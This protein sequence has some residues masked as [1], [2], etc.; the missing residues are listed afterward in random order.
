LATTTYLKQTSGALTEVRTVETSAGAGDASKIPN[1]TSAGILD[2]TVINA[3]ATTAANKIAKMNGSGILDDTIINASATSSAGK[4]V[5]MNGSGII[6]PTILNGTT[7]S[8]GAGDSAKFV[9][10]DST[11]RLDSTFLPVGVGAETVTATATEAISSGDVVNLY[12]SSGLKVRKADASN[13]REAH[14]FVL[15]AISNTA[16]GSVYV[17]GTD[18]G[19]S[20]RT[21]GAT[22]FLSA[23]TP[24]AVTETAPSTAGQI[25][26]VVGY[27]TGATQFT[28]ER[29]LPI[30]LA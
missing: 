22:Q 19:V 9:Q 17:E 30:T 5:K 25:V 7:T 4:V 20:S 3:S 8:A 24:G 29:S 27:A 12:N 16:T 23:T 6:A 26:Q 21:P 28:F 11:G 18:T 14:G 13:G 2:D 15:A 1:L 10:L